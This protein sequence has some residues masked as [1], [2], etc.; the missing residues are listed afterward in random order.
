[1][2]RLVEVEARVGSMAGLLEVV[3][4][5]RS[6]AG[7]RLRE[8][9]LALPAA[10]RYA[11][12]ISSAI[13]AVLRALG[14]IPAP[15]S[16]PEQRAIVL[17]GAE[18]GF[19]GA[20]TDRLIAAVQ[21][22][23]S[24]KDAL[25]VLG[26]RAASIAAEHGIRAAWMAPMGARPAN[27]PGTVRRLTEELYERI[28]RGDISRVDLVYATQGGPASAAIEHRT[29]FPL[30]AAS[31]AAGTEGRSPLGNLTPE[32]L[33]E[34]LT[35]EYVFALLAEAALE[36]LVSEN[37]ARFSAMSAARENVSRKLDTLRATAREIR[38]TEITTELLDVVTGAQALEG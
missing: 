23:A 9:Q 30:D 1:M 33:L 16:R 20:F 3:G 15:A 10:R 18:H 37:S 5:M 19:V 25:F 31:L 36:S 28:A 27:I 7:M 32:V 8:S 38:Q 34:Q 26:S 35:A 14:E 22:T 21:S 24:P 13:A 4:A 11:Q 12:T 2:T 29:L 6:L 17:Y